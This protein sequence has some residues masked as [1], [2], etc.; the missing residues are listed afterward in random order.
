M[1][2][3]KFDGYNNYQV[4]QVLDKN[5]SEVNAKIEQFKK[6]GWEHLGTLNVEDVK[7]VQLGW[8][9]DKGEPKKP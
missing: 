5:A 4:F 6:L 7:F 9:N 1:F 2:F 8:S 3:K